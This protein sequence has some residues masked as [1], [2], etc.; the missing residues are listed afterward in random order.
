M[1]NDMKY[2]ANA[3]FFNAINE[4]RAYS[5]EDMNRPYRKLISNGVFATPE[6]EASNELQV[7]AANDEMNVI[8]SAGDAFIGNKWFENPSNLMITISQNSQ[9]LPRK[10][11]IIAQI[12]KTQ[13]G[14]AGN[15][16]YRQGTASSNPVHPEINTEEDIFEI[17]LADILIS[18]SC[19]KVTQ[20]LITDCRGSE[21]CPWITS[22]IK[23]VDTSTLYAQWQAAYQK[24]Y[25]DQGQEFQTWF[26]GLQSQL[27]GDV[28]LNLLNLINTKADIPSY[29]TITLLAS[30]WVMNEGTQKYE[31]T[32]VDNTITEN[33][34]IQCRMEIEEQEKLANADGDSYNGGFIIRTT[35]LPTED[36]TMDI[37][38]QKM[39]RKVV[40]PT[41]PEGGNANEDGN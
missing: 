24:Y 29:Q 20:D 7:F 41:E 10:D 37:I 32:V 18:P 34:S 12:D 4:D 26:E 25:E 30:N 31:Y 14:R 21:E 5:A 35:E 16:V 38:I 15:I 1:T 8:V 40:T 19:V 28:A 2:E 23:Q 11:S 22:L 13:A 27:S 3:G 9:V 6:G 17:R 33:H 36:I 39:A